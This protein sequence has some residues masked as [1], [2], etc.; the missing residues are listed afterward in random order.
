[1]SRDYTDLTILLDRSGSMA[2]IKEGVIG[3]INSFIEEQA[4]VPGDGC[5]TFV[6]FDD[7]ASAVGAGEAF[8]QTVY[9][10]K[11]QG[12]VPLLNDDTFCPRGCTALI[13]A[14]VK[15]IDATGKRL[16]SMPEHLRPDKVV[17]VI[18]TDGIENASS[19]YTRA[20][21]NERISHQRSR[22]NWKFVFLGANQ[23][24]I[25]E[26]RKYGNFVHSNKTFVFSDQGS[27]AAMA[28]AHR[29]VRSWKVDGNTSAE[30]LLGPS[31]P[32]DE[33][34]RTQVKVDVSVKK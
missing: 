8:P 22:Y 29:A 19:K 1:M 24:A 9:E 25:A 32:D 7:L 31:D 23:D 33:S 17:F 34:K 30:I 6:Q 21:L 14:A 10:G 4:K 16:A 20:Q 15:T 12:Q 13:D 3:G 5:Y 18:M 27:A 2:S 11:S 26:G 28:C